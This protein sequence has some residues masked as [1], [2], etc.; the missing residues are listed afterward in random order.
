[1]P[2]I[3]RSSRASTARARSSRVWLSSNSTVRRLRADRERFLRNLP[4]DQLPQRRPRRHMRRPLPTP[5]V[6]RGR[7][8]ASRRLDD[9][10]ELHRRKRGQD[11]PPEQLRVVDR[12]RISLVPLRQRPFAGLVRSTSSRDRLIHALD[13]PTRHTRDVDDDTSRE[14]G[15]AAPR[16]HRGRREG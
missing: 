1:L 14:T 5:D 12:A 6:R 15:E 3:L 4:V 8:R 11:L 10:G 2:A 13:E 16:G 7:L 9:L